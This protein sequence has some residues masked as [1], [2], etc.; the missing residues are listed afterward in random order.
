[1]ASFCLKMCAIV[2][3]FFPWPHRRYVSHVP[4][5]CSFATVTTCNYKMCSVP[6]CL[7][8]VVTQKI[9]R[10]D[11]VFGF[12][13][14]DASC[15]IDI[16]MRDFYQALLNFGMTPSAGRMS[17]MLMNSMVNLDALT[18]SKEVLHEPVLLH[19]LPNDGAFRTGTEILCVEDAE[20]LNRLEKDLE[21]WLHGLDRPKR[22][23]WFG[24]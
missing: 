18:F 1:M 3:P 20:K 9:V 13:M 5:C 12:V 10:L 22:E 7:N 8:A 17:I 15:M 21:E 11:Q 16:G 23:F 24:Q 2:Y 6:R 14:V 19:V 4:F